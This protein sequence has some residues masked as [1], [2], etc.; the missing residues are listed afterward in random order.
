MRFSIPFVLSALLA[1]AEARIE[2]VA[3]PANIK[4]GESF[5]AILFARNYIQSVREIAVVVGS[6]PRAVPDGS[7]GRILGSYYLGPGTSPAICF[8]L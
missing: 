7:L 6:S 5:D 4:V 3:V 1:A 2:G 8:F